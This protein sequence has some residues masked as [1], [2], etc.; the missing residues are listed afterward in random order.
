MLIA[1]VVVLAL[2]A[3]GLDRLVNARTFQLAGELVHRVETGEKIV[4]LTF[5]D[6]PD[7]YT[8]EIIGPSSPP[9]KNR[10]D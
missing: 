3:L 8:K 4:A 2:S 7:E 1:V 9:S 5:D 6:V 10:Q